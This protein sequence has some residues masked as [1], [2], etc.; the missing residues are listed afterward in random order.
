[1]GCI[2][3]RGIRPSPRGELISLASRSSRVGRAD[4]NRVTATLFALIDD[5]TSLY[6]SSGGGVIASQDH[7]NGR[8]ANVAFLKAANDFYRHLKP[9]QSFQV[10]ASGRTIFYTLTDFGV[11][12]GGGPE[13]DLGNNRHLLSPLFHTGHAVL[14]PLIEPM[15]DEGQD[16]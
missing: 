3:P 5:T 1:M 9:C 13:N 7:E 14:T 2:P 15:N 4:G 12:T 8:E 16:S 10:P 11:L 6:L